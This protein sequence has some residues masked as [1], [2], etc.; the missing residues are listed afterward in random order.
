MADT[1]D[2]ERV[3]LVKFT[4]P[5]KWG[6]VE[7]RPLPVHEIKGKV[8]KQILEVEGEDALDSATPTEESRD[9]DS[10]R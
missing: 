7:L 10:L 1:Y 8:L 9:G 6:K 3:Y 2:D 5:V 4:R